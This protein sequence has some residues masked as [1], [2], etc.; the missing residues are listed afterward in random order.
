MTTVL[1]ASA[2]AY[3]TTALAAWPL[4][5]RYCDRHPWADIRTAPAGAK[6]TVAT[7][8]AA[9]WPLTVYLTI[10]DRTGQRQASGQKGDDRADM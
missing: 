10:S 7:F 5:W 4:T 2:I 3:L 6:A 8:L 9:A 1:A